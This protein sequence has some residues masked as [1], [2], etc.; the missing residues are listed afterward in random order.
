MMSKVQAEAL[1]TFIAKIRPDWDHPGILAAI[2]KAQHLAS[3]ASVAR[4]LCVL[5][6]N[7][8]LKTPALLAQ[9]GRHWVVDGQP[10]GPNNS[11][12]MH[13]H[14]HPLSVLPC[15][16]CEAEDRPHPCPPDVLAEMKAVI[17]QRPRLDTQPAKPVILTDAESAAIAR[18]KLEAQP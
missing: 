18:K 5:A 12:N 14:R 11:A 8:E 16:Q 6:D 7:R 10:T 4:A 17:A 13:C 3:P 2:G 15:P 9:A 1:A